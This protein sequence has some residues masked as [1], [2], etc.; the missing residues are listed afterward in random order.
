[1]S[2]HR[3]CEDIHIRLEDGYTLLLAKVRDS[4]GQLIP[5]KI[6]LDE[7]IGNT[8]GWFI[9]GGNNFTRT[10]RNISLEHTEQGPKLCAD[11][12]M[13]NGGSR[14]RQGIMLSEKIAN[15]DGHLKF[16]V[17]LV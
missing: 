3:S 6:R 13:R 10:A 2:F 16:L 12:E 8:D 1:M 5:R 11:L 4:H 15:N 14:G 7:H 17:S 9:W